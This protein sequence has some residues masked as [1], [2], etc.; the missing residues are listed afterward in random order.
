[1]AVKSA[2]MSVCWAYATVR[3][4]PA[5]T[6]TRYVS[7]TPEA[8]GGGVGLTGVSAGGD[9][10]G[11]GGEGGGEDTILGGG[12]EFL[13]GGGGLGGGGGGEETTTGG[14]GEQQSSGVPVQP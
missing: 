8:T 12:G 9:L 14:G 3:P 13:T 6:L 2:G 11:G 1:M 7:G 4:L 5:V 10:T